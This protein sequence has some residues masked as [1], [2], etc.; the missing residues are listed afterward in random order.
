[1]RTNVT[2]PIGDLLA[3]IRNANL[4]YKDDLVVAAS[5]MNRA[6]LAILEREG[7]I[8]G[9]EEEGEGV[10]RAFRVRLKYGRNRERAITGLRRI[11][12]PGRRIYAGRGELPR[13]LG[14][15]GIAILSTSQ[16][17]MTDREA[18][19]RGIGG[20]VLAYVW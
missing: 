10:H 15:L 1:M 14:G 16:G 13:V 3:R 17:V 8:A 18:A 9:F 7:Y 2:D 4:A 11:S 19:R 6:I 5:K 12:K 20:E